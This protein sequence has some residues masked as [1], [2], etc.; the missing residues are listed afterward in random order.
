MHCVVHAACF[1]LKALLRTLFCDTICHEQK[2]GALRTYES[3][4]AYNLESQLS[5]RPL[6]DQCFD[7]DCHSR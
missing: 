3:S 7:D 5:L 2:V 1:L 4:S 6:Q